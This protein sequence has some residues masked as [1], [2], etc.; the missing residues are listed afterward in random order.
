MT[1]RGRGSPEYRGSADGPSALALTLLPSLRRRGRSHGLMCPFVP[2][3]HYTPRCP[4][5]EVSG[6]SK[7]DGGWGRVTEW[8]IQ[9]PT[10][11]LGRGSGCSSS[12]CYGI[13]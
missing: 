8:E 3:T 1:S 12:R 11:F 5:E 4:W 10:C 2:E 7:D 9:V 6:T 13:V